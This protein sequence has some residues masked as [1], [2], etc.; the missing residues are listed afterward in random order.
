MNKAGTSNQALA[1]EL[2]RQGWTGTVNNISNWRNALAPIPDEVL[3]LLVRAFGSDPELDGLGEVVAFLVRRSPWLKPYLK[4]APASDAGSEPTRGARLEPVY[5]G[6]RGKYQGKR[7]VLYQD[8]QGHYVAGRTR[9]EQD[10]RLFKRKDEL[11]RAMKADRELRVRMV[12]EMGA[13]PSL[14]HQDS[15]VWV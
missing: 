6:K 3:P 5:Y 4:S 11:I 9:F 7:F 10:K 1:M 15:L 14:I 2:T 8:A 13:P 12:P